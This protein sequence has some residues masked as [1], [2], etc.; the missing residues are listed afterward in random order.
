MIKKIEYVDL[1]WKYVDF[2]VKMF[3]NENEKLG[4]YTWNK[5]K[6]N[7][8]INDFNKFFF[9]YWFFSFFNKELKIVLDIFRV[10]IPAN[11]VIQP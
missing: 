2:A 6:T 10:F 4:F 11:N 9:Q 8:R 5:T 7:K 1:C 3:K